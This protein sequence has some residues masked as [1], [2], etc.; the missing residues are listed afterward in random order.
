MGA[1]GD[2]GAF[3]NL[4]PGEGSVIEVKME[5]K[6]RHRGTGKNKG[7]SKKHAFFSA[8]SAVKIFFITCIGK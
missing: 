7:S 4:G 3:V 8:R 1:E 2:F 6:F 5:R